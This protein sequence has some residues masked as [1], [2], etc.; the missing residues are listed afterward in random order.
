MKEV[1]GPLNFT[2]PPAG[3]IEH[4]AL[5]D[6]TAIWRYHCSNMIA[7]YNRR[8]LESDHIVSVY[9]WRVENPAGAR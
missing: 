6:K 4:P 8:E 5:N 7:I 3:P 1:I 2:G 9:A